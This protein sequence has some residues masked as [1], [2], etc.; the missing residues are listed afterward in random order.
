MTRGFVLMTLGLFALA[1]ASLAQAQMTTDPTV[2]AYDRLSPGGQK[3]AQALFAA[4]TPAAP[5][6]ATG[7]TTGT[8]GTTTGSGAMTLD[9]IAAL[10]LD[11]TGWGRIFQQMKDAGLVTQKNLGQ[12]VRQYEAMQHAAAPS[13]TTPTSDTAG[14]S[15]GKGFGR[16]EGHSD[17]AR[18]Y[19]RASGGFGSGGGPSNDNGQGGGPGSGH[20]N[21]Y[22]RG[23]GHGRR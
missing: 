1:T 11:G 10:K 8:V 19:L 13:T 9:Q 2:C 23:G 6:P 22:G 21:A 18:D 4:Q 17:F 12:A 3:I 7:S 16:Q 15:S 14:S 5:R 20:G